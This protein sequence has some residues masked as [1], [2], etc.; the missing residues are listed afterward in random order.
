MLENGVG[1]YSENPDETETV[2]QWF[3]PLKQ[4]CFNVGAI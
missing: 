3:G 4:T 1:V 2:A